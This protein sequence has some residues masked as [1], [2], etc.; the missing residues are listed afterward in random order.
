MERRLQTSQSRRECDGPLPGLPNC[1][2]PNSHLVTPMKHAS[3]PFAAIAA[4]SG[5]SSASRAEN[6]ISVPTVNCTAQGDS[7]VVG[8]IVDSGTFSFELVGPDPSDSGAAIQ[9]IVDPAGWAHSAVASGLASV[10]SP[11][12]LQSSLKGQLS[13]QLM[14]GS[15]GLT[16]VWNYGGPGNPTDSVLAI[17]NSAGSNEVAFALS[18][19]A[20]VQFVQF[21][22]KA[23][24]HK[25]GNAGSAT[26]SV[27]LS[28]MGGDEPVARVAASSLVASRDPSGSGSVNDDSL[29]N[30]TLVLD[31]GVFT[32]R[33]DTSSHVD[34]LAAVQG[35]GVNLDASGSGLAELSFFACQSITSQPA[36]VIARSGEG[37]AFTVQCDGYGNAFAFTWRHN[38][39]PIAPGTSGYRVSSG[40]LWSSLSVAAAGAAQ[41]G[42]YDVVVTGPLCG[43]LV[44]SS[45]ML[46]V[47]GVGGGPGDVD[48]NGL[49][50]A[51]D[52]ALLLGAW[53]TAEP[54]ADFD[55]D[56]YVGGMDLAILLGAWST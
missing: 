46:T 37:A 7:A 17:G 15:S 40:P 35:D 11:S 3:W 52:L 23:E 22:C 55:C 9:S 19:R 10:S 28:M 12:W 44:S 2:C 51:A 49:V 14:T 16:G 34:G 29:Q 4:L 21:S 47:P 36:D 50:D 5:V 1:G 6:L 56:G 30:Q 43:D 8:P 54:S 38:G 41:T 32:V 53:A 20:A 42:S 27:S 48:T 24:A 26:G 18:R 33:V 25:G 45:A 31:P 13:V 39:V